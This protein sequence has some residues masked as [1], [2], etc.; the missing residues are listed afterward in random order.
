VKYLLIKIFWFFGRPVQKLYWF[1]FRP[2][3]RGV[4]CIIENNDKFLLVKLNYAHHK[5]IIPGGGIKKNESSLQ[6]VIRETKEEVGIDIKD[7]VYIGS[8]ISQKDY[9]E[10]IVEIFLTNSDILDTKIDPIE[11]EKAEWFERSN[12][13]ENIGV[14]I[15]KVFKIY[16]EFRLKKNN[17]IAKKRD[18]IIEFNDKKIYGDIISKDSQIDILFIHGAGT[19]NRVR[20]EQFRGFLASKNISSAMVDLIGH[21]ETGGDIKNTSLQERTE[22]ILAVVKDLKIETPLKIIAFSMGGYNAI[23]LTELL[24]VELLVL[25]APAV[26]DTRA[27]EVKFGAGFS[28]IIRSEYSWQK[29]DAWNILDT[30]K[31][32][33][34]LCI[35]DKDDVI[36]FEIVQTIYDS[37]KNAKYKEIFIMPE[38]GHKVSLYL[39]EKPDMMEIVTQKII[40]LL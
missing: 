9:K 35:G 12:F 21:G 1:I 18:F 15:P 11:I 28:E 23:K 14:S 33:L 32:K 5:W 38:S 40:K 31:G 16:D 20:Y 39:K 29:S 27:R 4:K 13:P 7:L 26:Y 30:Y 36:P 2:T 17:K 22:E 6:A 3:L 8:Y 19:T 10:T 25:F 24:E 37:A 34:L